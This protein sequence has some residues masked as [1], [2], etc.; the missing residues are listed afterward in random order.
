M[1]ADLVPYWMGALN[2]FYIMGPLN[3]ITKILK[4][5]KS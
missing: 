1:R 4:R 2:G 3:L 5:G